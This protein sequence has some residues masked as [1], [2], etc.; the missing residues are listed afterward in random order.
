MLTCRTVIVVVLPH[1]QPC[2]AYNFTRL[3]M[4]MLALIDN[5]TQSPS[6]TRRSSTD[7][8]DDV[9]DD[10]N[11]ELAEIHDDALSDPIAHERI[12]NYRRIV[13]LNNAHVSKLN[14]LIAK[15]SVRRAPFS[16]LDTL[17][18]NMHIYTNT[19]F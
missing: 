10:L 2:H 14:T 3:P 15:V 17:R 4:R 13:R 18:R 5:K 19:G 11:V 8:V 16:P 6:K 1:Y 7:H 9:D 12:A